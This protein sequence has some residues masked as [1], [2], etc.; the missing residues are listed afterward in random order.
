MAKGT[1]GNEMK[2][3]SRM[4]ARSGSTSMSRR[5]SCKRPHFFSKQSAASFGKLAVCVVGK[6]VG[7]Q[8][9]IAS[10]TA[11]PDIM[12]F[13]FFAAP[14]SYSKQRAQVCGGPVRQSSDPMSHDQRLNYSREFA[15]A[16]A[17]RDAA[18]REL[19]LSADPQTLAKAKAQGLKLADV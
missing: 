9:N 10:R 18:I 16:S 17:S 8:D 12:K 6:A 4:E 15:R 7:S 19:K 5:I 3:L 13:R 2:T 1:N 11:E 14:F